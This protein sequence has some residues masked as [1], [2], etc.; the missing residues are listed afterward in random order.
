M[1]QQGNNP[2]VRRRRSAG[3]AR[4]AGSPLL[5]LR[6]KRGAKP[7][8]LDGPCGADEQEIDL[9]VRGPWRD[10]ELAT[11]QVLRLARATEPALSP[12]GIPAWRRPARRLLA[13]ERGHVAI[14]LVSQK[15]GK[16]RDDLLFGDPHLPDR[17]LLEPSREEDDVKAVERLAMRKPERLTRENG[18]QSGEI[19]AIPVVRKGLGVSDGDLD[20]TC[21]EE[22][23]RGSE[24]GRAFQEDFV[25]LP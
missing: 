12:M 23:C 14:Q 6:G 3:A 7:L 24:G 19:A 16:I 22:H 17:N 1:V 21:L 20:W 10:A 9:H 2:R 15:D 11:D 13:R 18:D 5:R 4:E 25:R 8:A